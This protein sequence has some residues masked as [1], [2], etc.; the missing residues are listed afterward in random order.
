MDD[1]LIEKAKDIISKITHITIATS[2]TTGQPW[3]SPVYGAYDEHYN[4]YWT[5]WK[6][7]QHSINIRENNKIFLVIYDSTV[8]EDNHIF[9]GVYIQAKAYELTN[10]EEIESA[11]EY[12]TKRRDKPS[13]H[14]PAEFFGNFPRRVYKAVPE[15]LWLNNTGNLEGNF[16]DTR[17]EIDL[18][19]LV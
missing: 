18:K 3:N 13:N 11:R 6:E 9:K 14:P 7:S 16:I 17:I 15:K 12:I 10:E 5:S 4:F 19:M 8:P 1:Q 2:D